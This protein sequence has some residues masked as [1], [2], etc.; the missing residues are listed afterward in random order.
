MFSSKTEQVISHGRKYKAIGKKVLFV[1]HI[2]D[3]RYTTEHFVVSHNGSKEKSVNLENLKDL[4]DAIESFDV[5]IIEEAQFFTDLIETFYNWEKL[6]FLNEK[7][8]IVSGLSSDYNMKK[9]GQVIDLIPLADKIV[10]LNGL[11]TQCADGTLGGFTQLKKRE[12]A[13]SSSNI[14]VGHTDLYECVC[15]FHHT[16]F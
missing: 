12:L 6:N 9:I 14:L 16:H 8:F 7:V 5:I 15:R 3:T 10:K 1:N 13:D 11:C 2:T 4:N